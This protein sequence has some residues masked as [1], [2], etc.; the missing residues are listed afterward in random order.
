LVGSSTQ[1]IARGV[2]LVG[3]TGHALKRIQ[4]G[5]TDIDEAFRKI[6]VGAQAQSAG[7][8]EINATFTEMDQVTQQNAAMVE[9]S[10]A[11]TQTLA[12]ETEALNQSV[13]RF[14]ISEA[15]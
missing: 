7:L 4:Q 1:H 14:K 2:H 10:T 11:S 3:E 8:A 5:V 15:A 9:Q 13:A 12:Q 6:A